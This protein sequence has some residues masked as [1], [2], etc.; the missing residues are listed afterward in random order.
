MESTSACLSKAG[1]KAFEK[2]VATL[3]QILARAQ[4]DTDAQPTADADRGILGR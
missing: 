1:H 3:H 2:H 4:L